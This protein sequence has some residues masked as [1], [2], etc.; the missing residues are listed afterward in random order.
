MISAQVANPRSCRKPRRSIALVLTVR[1]RVKDKGE[2]ENDGRDSESTVLL[3]TM[4]FATVTVVT[5]V[6]VK[7][8]SLPSLLLGFRHFSDPRSSILSRSGLYLMGMNSTRSSALGSKASLLPNLVLTYIYIYTLK[9]PLH[10]ALHPSSPWN[11]L[12]PFS[13]VSFLDPL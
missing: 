2:V 10:P 8:K 3:L 11:P 12:D 13:P 7:K 1:T 9:A 5:K 6:I 4:V